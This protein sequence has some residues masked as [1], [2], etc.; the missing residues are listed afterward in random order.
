MDIDQEERQNN[1]QDN[2]DED[3]ERITRV[4]AEVDTGTPSDSDIAQ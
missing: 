2:E 4:S 1:A 3:E